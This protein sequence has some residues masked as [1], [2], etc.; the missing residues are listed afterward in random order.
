MENV[1][2]IIIT[3]ASNK[4][5]I[6]KKLSE[7]KKL[8]N[9]KFLTFKELKKKLFFDYNS[10][11]LEYIMQ[12]YNVTLNVAKTYLEHL[13]YLQ[14]IKNEKVTFLLELKEKL[15]E[16]GLLIYDNLFHEYINNKKV[17]LYGYTNLTREEELILSKLDNV[18]RI[19]PSKNSYIPKVFQLK[20][21]R[22]EVEYVV[23]RISKLYLDGVSLNNIKLIINPEYINTIKYYSNIYHIPIQFKD[24]HTFYSTSIAQDFLSSYFE[25]SIEDNI[26]LL[27]NKY[28]NIN[29]LITIINKSALISDKTIRKSFIIED[30]KHSFIKESRYLEAVEEASLDEDFDESCFVF[31]LGFHIGAYPVVYKDDDFLSDNIRSKLGIDTS[32]LMNKYAKEQL[33]ANISRIK[34]LVITCQISDN[35]TI[36]PSLIIEEMGLSIEQTNN[37]SLVSYSKLNTKLNYA[38]SLDQYFKF[39]IMNDFMSIYRNSVNIDYL[40]YR[41][42]FSGVNINVLRERIGEELVLAY[43]SMEMYN[44]CAFKYYVNKILRIDQYEETFKTILGTIAHHILELSLEREIIIPVEIMKFVKEKEYQLSSKEFFYLEKLSKELEF[45]INTIKKQNNKSSL[46]NNLFESE[47]YVYFD[48]DGIKISFKGLIDKVMYFKDEEQ[49][50]LAVVDYKTGNPVITLDNLKYGL[51]IQLPIYLYLLKKADRFKD[52]I[53]AGFYIQKVLSPIPN[54]SD[55]KTLNDIKEENLR[56]QGYSNASTSILEYLDEDYQNSSMV[57]GLRFKNDGSFY[58]TAKVLD[59]KQMDEITEVVEKQIENV[60]DN[61]LQG[62]FEINPKV[63]GGKNIACEYC[64]YHDICYSTKNDEVILGGETHELDD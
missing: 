49:E 39:N 16:K 64:K 25:Y 20:D 58:S 50:I 52:A 13:Y 56:L 15:E 48:K 10:L 42:K 32:T 29:D 8:Y 60:I 34:N 59:N 61:I 2:T 27:K 4:K 24:R 41:N 57:K 51:N 28:D 17:V 63:I 18:E 35:K 44:E 37:N 45:I 6:L 53:I 30:M 19:L 47:L 40:G 21:K 62:N 38:N 26:E 33:K 55:K 5:Y 46:K 22:E 43:T 11:T 14:D 31:L 23:N 36:F 7:E 1:C 12:E 9:L 3:N 54:V